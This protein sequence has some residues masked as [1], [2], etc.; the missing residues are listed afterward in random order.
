SLVVYALENR[1]Q[2]LDTETWTDTRPGQ[3][4]SEP[5]TVPTAH[6]QKDGSRDGLLLLRAAGC[7]EQP[8]GFLAQPL[9]APWESVSTQTLTSDWSANQST[10]GSDPAHG[11]PH[12]PPHSPLLQKAKVSAWKKYARRDE[13]LAKEKHQKRGPIL[14]DI[15]GL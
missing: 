15:R 10:L 5:D 9:G 7:S 14:H 2:I 13:R 1:S 6:L 8:C 12:P 3:L 11:G 4:S